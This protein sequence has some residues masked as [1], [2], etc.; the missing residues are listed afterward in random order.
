ME[1]PD[2]LLAR[3]FRA[4]LAKRWWIVVIYAVLLPPAAWFAL[5]VTSDNSIDRLVVQ[6][7]PDYADTGPW[8]GLCGGGDY[9][10]LLTEA[11]APFAPAALARVDE[12]ERV[13]EEIPKVEP[14][15]ALSIY[16]RARGGLART[17]EAAEDFR[18]FAS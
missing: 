16:R 5:K 15:S 2:G 1:Q 13:L 9:I 12:L 7:D 18:R 6:S 17:P 8:D 3:L 11:P 10:F 4:V 14:S